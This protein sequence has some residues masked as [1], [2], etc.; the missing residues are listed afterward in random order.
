MAKKEQVAPYKPAMS[1]AAVKLKTGKT[2]AQW[3]AV[4]DKAGAGNQT[5]RAIARLISEKFDVGPWWC[6]MVTVEYERGRGMREK[7][8][9][10]TGYSVS[11]SKTIDCGLSSLYKAAADARAR[12]KWFPEG[13]FKPSSKTKNKYLRG[14]WNGGVSIEMNFIKKESGK[15]QIS[16]QLGKLGNRE[17]VE[18]E[19]ATWKDAL[20]RLAEGLA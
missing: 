2:W 6:Q 10:A 13:A 16:V 11:V 19:R 17:D 7:H 14:T 8:E 1:D 12:K 5:H 3:F 20:A 18:V 4:L 9:T 15:S